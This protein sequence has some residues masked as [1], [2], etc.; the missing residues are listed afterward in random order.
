MRDGAKPD[1]KDG[2]EDTPPRGGATRSPPS[3][4]K[5]EAETGLPIG[6]SAQ[7]GRDRAGFA[8]RANHGSL[9]SS[10]EPGLLLWSRRGDFLLN[11]RQHPRQCD[12]ERE[13]GTIEVWE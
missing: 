11:P 6:I 2:Q 1:E 4:I 12:G 10:F 9:G 8:A 3:E 5:L 7:L 13:Q